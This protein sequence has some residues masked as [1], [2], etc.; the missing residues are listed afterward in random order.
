MCC[1][2]LQLCIAVAIFIVLILNFLMAVFAEFFFHALCTN[3]EMKRCLP[4]W[5]V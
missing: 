1:S 2:L 4:E 3:S 5:S